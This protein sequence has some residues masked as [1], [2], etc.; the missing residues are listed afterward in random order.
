MYCSSEIAVVLQGGDVLN[1][2]RVAQW[3]LDTPESTTYFGAVGT[4]D[5]SK[6]LE[7][8]TKADRVVA[9]FDHKPQLP[10]GISSL[11]RLVWIFI[12]L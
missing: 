2:I 6:Q 12:G 3:L 1:S 7:R 8:C 5:N 10:T 11:V 4:D 9:H